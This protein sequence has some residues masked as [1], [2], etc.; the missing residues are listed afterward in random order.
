MLRRSCSDGKTGQTVVGKALFGPSTSSASERLRSRPAEPIRDC[1]D[2]LH[3]KSECTG[4][5]FTYEPSSIDSLA[6]RERP[7]TGRTMRTAKPASALVRLKNSNRPHQACNH[8]NQ[9]C[10]S[11]A[12][13]R[14]GDAFAL[15][16]A[17]ARAGRGGYGRGGAIVKPRPTPARDCDTRPTAAPGRRR[18][19][20]SWRALVWIGP[21][22]TGWPAGAHGAPCFAPRRKTPCAR[23]G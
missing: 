11:S 7:C 22:P 12:G 15:R 6:K 9:K 5:I 4:A 18:R 23:P 1:G 10:S 17:M 2:V 20:S 3:K 19:P 16:L 8:L 13:D 14:G 21:A